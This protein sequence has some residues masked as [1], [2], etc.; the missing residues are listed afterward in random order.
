MDVL[1]LIYHYGRGLIKANSE[2]LT[3][4]LPTHFERMEHHLKCIWR[5]VVSPNGDASSVIG[6]VHRRRWTARACPS[7]RPAS[8]AA[9][10]PRRPSTSTRPSDPPCRPPALTPTR[11]GGRFPVD[12][13]RRATPRGC[14]RAAHRRIVDLCS[15]GTLV[16]W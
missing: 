5:R 15:P 2:R 11:D 14:G 6:Y 16:V 4:R 8:R 10:P 13:T 12:A 3:V 1:T 9:R 7:A